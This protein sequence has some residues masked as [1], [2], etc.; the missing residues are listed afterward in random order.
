MFFG[1]KAGNDGN[2]EYCGC[3]AFARKRIGK[4]LVSHAIETAKEYGMSKLEVGTGNSSVSQL[5]LYQNV[6][7]VFFY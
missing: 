6:D 4:K 2:Y 5:A 1:N 7:F 3:R